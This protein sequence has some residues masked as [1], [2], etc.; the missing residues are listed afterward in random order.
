MS[1]D[2]TVFIG[3]NSS[4]MERNRR[5]GGYLLRRKTKEVCVSVIRALLMFG[6]CFMIIS[7]LISRLSMSLMEEQDLYDTTIVL[8]P[9][10]VTLENFT[11][12]ARATSMPTSMLN[13][14]W[15]SVRPL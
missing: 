12:V 10:N 2:N 6:L 1:K 14:L 8:L 11:A 4:F 7:P 15:I 3:K 5:S 9:R 13:T